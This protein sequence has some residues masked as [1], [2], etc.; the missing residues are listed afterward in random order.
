[1]QT[2]N[3]RINMKKLFILIIFLFGVIPAGLY[4]QTTPERLNMPGDNLNLYAVLK[5]FQE[6]KTLEAFERSLN[7]ENNNINNLDLNGDDKTDYI[8][9]IDNVDGNVHT[10]VLQTDI[11]ASEKQDIAVFTVQKDNTGKA[12]VQLIGDETLYG[13]DYII[14]PAT[15]DNRE[16]PNPGYNGNNSALVEEQIV[17]D[18]PLVTSMY[19]PG[20]V[21]WQSP[22]YWNSYPAYWHPWQPLYWHAYWGYQSNWNGWYYG[23]YRRAHNYRYDHWND[24]YVR[25]RRAE[26]P[27]V[28]QRE[29]KNAYIN[30]YSKPETKNE[31]VALFYKRNPE[32]NRQ[33]DRINTD[34]PFTRQGSEG[35]ET[36][37]SIQ[38]PQ[39]TPQHVREL[40]VSRDRVTTKP[41]EP[42]PAFT[43]P[44]QQ[45]PDQPR[46]VE[47]NRPRVVDNNRPRPAQN[48]QPR[49][50][51]NNKPRAA[52]NNRPV[53]I[54][55]PFRPRA[56]TT[57]PNAPRPVVTTPDRPRPV[58]QRPVRRKE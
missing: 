2:R 7:D 57:P 33:P 16:T 38:Q 1:M 41:D 14:E 56:V 24:F 13:K 35:P 26:A 10:I 12:Q 11:S 28:I 20:Y 58:M 29:R 21:V 50:V 34:K 37:A 9:V 48:N 6:S 46:A 45:K 51:E 53:N 40:P 31:G 18:W 55:K 36:Q 19:T 43:K 3:K 22:F 23:H 30:T 47:N 5:L 25:Q 4:A 44:I 52:E 32:L 42:R 49:V 27:T 39:A 54:N 8:K 17:S 15:A